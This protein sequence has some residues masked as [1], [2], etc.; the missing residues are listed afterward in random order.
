MYQAELIFN[1]ELTPKLGAK[2]PF[3]IHSNCKVVSI[4]KGETES[5]SY[6]DINFEDSEGRSHNKRLWQ[7]KGSYPRDNESQEEA[8]VREERRNLAHLVRLAHIFMGESRLKE[9]SGNSYNEFVTKAVKLLN[10]TLKTKAVNLKLTYDRDGAY[11]EFSNYPDYIEEHVP[12]QEPTLQY[13]KW[14]KDNRCTPKETVK[15]SGSAFAD[16]L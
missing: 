9:L 8:L 1:E 5:N 2:I 4:E 14:E 16:L 15:P 3:G 12:G 7:P 10:P 13:S 11:S 6:V